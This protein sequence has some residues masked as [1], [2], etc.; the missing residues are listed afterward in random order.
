M[1]RIR[2]IIMANEDRKLTLKEASRRGGLKTLERYGKNFFAEMGRKGSEVR[3]RKYGPDY[4]KM[5]G[6]K[7]G[8]ATLAKYGIEYLRNLRRSRQSPEGE[9]SKDVK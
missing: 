3:L 9:E 2:K 4:Y 8:D 7:G 6:K 5:I 1:V